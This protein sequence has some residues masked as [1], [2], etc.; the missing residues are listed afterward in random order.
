MW[1]LQILVSI[2]IAAFYCLSSHNVLQINKYLTYRL[3]L[4][5]RR[6]RITDFAPKV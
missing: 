3:G 2:T 4:V 5:N 1:N 6:L